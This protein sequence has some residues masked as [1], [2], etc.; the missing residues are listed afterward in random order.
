M[1][2]HNKIVPFERRKKD[3]RN[4]PTPPLSPYSLNGKRK[5]SRRAEDRKNYYVDR[6]GKRSIFFA[7]L[8]L[9]LCLLDGFFTLH[10]LNHGAKEVNPFM[11]LALNYGRF[12]FLAVKYILNGLAVV[13]LLMHKN[14]YL[15]KHKV[16]VR[17]LAVFLIIAYLILVVYEV[18]LLKY[19][20]GKNMGF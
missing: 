8:V 11:Q 16:N 6:Y 15:F 5:K 2:K 10:F 1:N 19:V 13:V 4:R 20:I 18:S 17:Y 14:F 12:F 3:R 7:F 9:A